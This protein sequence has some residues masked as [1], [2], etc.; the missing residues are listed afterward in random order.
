MIRLT[1]VAE[2]LGAAGLLIPQLRKAAGVGLALYA[3][4]V[5][6][7][8]VKHA[9]DAL[10]PGGGLPLSWLYH[11][12]RLLLQPVIIWACL[13]VGEVTDWPFCSRTRR[14]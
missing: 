10:E 14:G 12:P 8:N 7:A 4:C 13:W 5:W 2:L 1:G 11:G 3:L 9:L 6:P